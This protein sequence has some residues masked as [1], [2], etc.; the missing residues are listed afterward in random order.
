[1]IGSLDRWWQ[2]TEPSHVAVR[3]A[4]LVLVL[5]V[6]GWRSARNEN[7][8]ALDRDALAR[9]QALRDIRLSRA[10]VVES[11]SL[12]PEPGTGDS[13]WW[14]DRLDRESQR[15]GVTLNRNDTKPSEWSVGTFRLER[16]E[17]SGT[18]TYDAVLKLMLWMETSSPRVRLQDFSLEPGPP[19][20]VRATLAVL[21]PVPGGA[22]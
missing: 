8:R 5:V 4:L 11:Q 12:L 6:W 15:A 7:L 16:R 20:V 19:G 17:L 10:V 3:V 18:G 9:A 14:R 2:R 1:M 13:A 21:G 22:R